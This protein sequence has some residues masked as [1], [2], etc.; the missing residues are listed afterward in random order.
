MH[1][2][3]LLIFFQNSVTAE[4]RLRARAYDDD[5]DNINDVEPEK[6]MIGFIKWTY[7]L[8]VILIQKE[9]AQLETNLVVKFY[10]WVKIITKDLFASPFLFL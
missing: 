5:T 7:W 6:A 3:I 4:N 2:Q 1:T 8:P 9:S 10:F